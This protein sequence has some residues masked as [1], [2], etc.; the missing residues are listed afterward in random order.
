MKNILFILFSLFISFEAFTQEYNI[1]V[2]VKGDY[3]LPIYLGYHYGAETLLLDTAKSDKL[4]IYT[5]SKKEKLGEGVYFVYLENKTYFDFLVG[6]N[7]QFRININLNSKTKVISFDNSEQN[8]NFLTFQADI[9]KMY[10]ESSLLVSRLKANK[11]NTDSTINIQNEIYAFNKT[12]SDFR[13]KIV[14][15][16][17]GSLFAAIIS[18]MIEPDINEFNSR[19]QNT[20]TTTQA[21]NRYTFYKNYYFDYYDFS[22]TRLLR[23]EILENKIKTFFTSVVKKHPDSIVV[24]SRKLLKKAEINSYTFKFTFDWLLHKYENYDKVGYDKVFVYLA[25]N[26]ILNNKTPWLN[27][28]QIEGYR[29]LVNLL[30]PMLISKIAPELSLPD[31][32][33]KNVSLNK[34]YADATVL[35]FYQLD[36]EKSSEIL[37]K[38][39]TDIQI[40][41]KK[42]IMVYTV[43]VNSTYDIWKT[44]PQ[45]EKKGWKNV[46]DINDMVSKSGYYIEQAPRVFILNYE[47]QIISNNVEIKSIK[48]VLSR[49]L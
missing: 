44:M 36:Q 2:K 46:C 25:E 30:K 43:C 9:S 41:E 7:Q 8:T 15:E 47:K 22:D 13:L 10:Q 12:I 26:Y 33:N 39:A 49:I 45:I 5:F 4:G 28:K 18:S 32:N 40:F 1:T 27:K 38:I 17:K 11:N 19:P 21:I 31:I 29:Q 34:N 48:R 23:S 35:V 42:D 16:N 24:E 20:N 14:E 37:D 3:S 6:D